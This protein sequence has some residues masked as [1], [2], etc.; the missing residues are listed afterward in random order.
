MLTRAEAETP[1]TR[2]DA[3]TSAR[4]E[5]RMSPAP[6][7]SIRRGVIVGIVAALI[8]GGLGIFA[9]GLRGF[10]KRPDCAQLSPMEC[11]LV[12]EEA[13]AIGI[14]QVW[15]GGALALLGLAVVIWARP[16]TP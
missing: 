15:F 5:A 12:T 10:W 16:R 8:V 3:R 13:R 14:R 11:S 4:Y 6:L 2:L 1:A 7:A 9:I